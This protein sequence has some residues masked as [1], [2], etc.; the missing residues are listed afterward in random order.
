MPKPKSK[1]TSRTKSRA[2]SGSRPGSK[3][4]GFKLVGS[5]KKSKTEQRDAADDDAPKTLHFPEHTPWGD[6]TAEPEAPSDIIDSIDRQID[7]A[8]EALGRLEED[9]D[10]LFRITDDDPDDDTPAAA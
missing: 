9:A 7:R 5:E 3:D 8:Q 4:S 1:S 6:R 2:Q 10:V